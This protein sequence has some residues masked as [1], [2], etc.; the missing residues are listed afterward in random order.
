MTTP[1]LHK[2]TVELDNGREETWYLPPN[3]VPAS[4]YAT[5]VE[6]ARLGRSL[7]SR[8]DVVEAHVLLG[9]SESHLPEGETEGHPTPEEA[10]AKLKGSGRRRRGT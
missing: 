7:R 1:D 5:G 3:V 6:M 10:R 4:L 9:S 8:D 2:F